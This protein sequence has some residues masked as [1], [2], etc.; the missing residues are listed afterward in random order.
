MHDEQAGN[1]LKGTLDNLNQG[2]LLLAED[3]EAAKHNFLLRG[4]FRKQERTRAKALA[5]AE[6]DTREASPAAE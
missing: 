5:E 6:T 2:S 1:D 3:L 4:F